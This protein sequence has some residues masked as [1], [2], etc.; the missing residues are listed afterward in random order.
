M[1][2]TIS[3]HGI[4]WCARDKKIFLEPKTISFARDT[5]SWEGDSN[6]CARDAVV[7]VYNF[8]PHVPLQRRLYTSTRRVHS[9]R[10]VACDCSHNCSAF[11]WKSI[12]IVRSTHNI[13]RHRCHMGPICSIPTVLPVCCSRTT[14]FC[15]R[16]QLNY[17]KNTRNVGQCP[18]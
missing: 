6:S 15:S 9:I 7:T 12:F 4:A 2:Y 11:I 8:F 16:V 5:N 1:S 3:W 18:T 17:F 13:L 10:F 14:V